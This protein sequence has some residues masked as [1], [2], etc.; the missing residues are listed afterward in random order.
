MP[1]GRRT[2]SLTAQLLVFL[3]VH[4]L[5]GCSKGTSAGDPDP[6]E[7]KLRAAIASDLPLG[8]DVPKIESFLRA[9]GLEHSTDAAAGTVRAIK[10]NVAKGNMTTKDVTVVFKLAGGKLQSYETRVVLTGL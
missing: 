6:D 1:A 2:F 8:S 10:R 9:N 3:M 5:V 4:G 7:V